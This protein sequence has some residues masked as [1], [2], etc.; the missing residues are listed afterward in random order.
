MG[1]FVRRQIKKPGAAPG[2]LLHTGPRKVENVRIRFL[3]YDEA[4]FQEREVDDIEAVW[5]FRDSPTVS[6]VN[7]DGLHAVQV[8]EAVGEHFSIHPLVLEDV[9]SAGQRAKLEEH[10][11][12]LYVVLPMLSWNVEAGVVEVEQLSLILGP[13]W[14]I[15]FQER[16]GDV[17]EPVRERV[18][19]ANR[20]IRARGAD[21][22][23]YALIDVI[24]DHYFAILEAIGEVT[25]RLELEA[26]EE[27]S[28]STMEGLHRL[29][30]E[31]LVVRRAIWP[32]REMC[33]ALVRTES[34]LVED[35]TRVFLRDVYDHAVQ[36]IDTL[37]SL[38]DVVGGSIDLYL[39]QVGHKQNEIMK[40]LTVMASI[41]IP[42][43]FFAGI[44][45]M[46]FETMPELGIPWAYPA[47]LGVMG[48]LALGMVLYFRRR[49]W[50]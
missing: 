13:T 6:W 30:R 35:A 1:R 9:V 29:K 24:V 8:V 43:T 16:V 41:F 36:V 19:S 2:T 37:E 7:I 23:A 39:S 26:L 20:R 33:N 49:G 45:G 10:E 14:V 4:S 32:L 17:F 27:P 25:E 38:R 5:P 28:P 47:L 40:V 11:G 42:L 15:T 50:L 44:Y 3:D 46:N 34:P 12:Y 48:V 18:R 31:M 21:Y 22:L